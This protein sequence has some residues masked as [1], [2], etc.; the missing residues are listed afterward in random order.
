M[1][2]Q[3]GVFSNQR[4]QT[5]AGE[6]GDGFPVTDLEAAGYALV[7]IHAQDRRLRLLAERRAVPGSRKSLPPS[8]RHGRVLVGDD[9]TPDIG[10]P[11]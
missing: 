4:F 9:I 2:R 5:P 8:E 10:D 1:F 11:H 7:S 3:Q 6:A